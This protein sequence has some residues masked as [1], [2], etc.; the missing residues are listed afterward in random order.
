MSKRAKTH[1]GT[2]KRMS[3]TGSGKLVRGRQQGGHLMVKKRP[4]RRR[5][6]RRRVEV[7]PADV[8]KIARLLP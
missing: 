6:L 2:A 8:P 5:S 4:K 7:H 1:Q 3:R